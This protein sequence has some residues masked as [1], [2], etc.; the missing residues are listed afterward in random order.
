MQNSII[1]SASK[2]FLFEGL[3]ESKIDSLLKLCSP[4]IKTYQKNGVIYSPDKF[5]REV[6]IIIGGK[7]RVERLSDDGRAIPLN[8][9]SE[10]DAFGIVAAFSERK[11]F[12]THIVALCDSTVAFFTKNDV[13]RLIEENNK[14]ALNVIGF[15][16]NRIDFLNDKILTFSG[17]NVEQKLAKHIYDLYISSG[18]STFPFNKKKASEQ[19]NVG[20][21]SLYRAIDSMTSDGIISFD[22]RKIIIKDPQGLE[23]LL[24]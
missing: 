14:I 24:K 13:V 2:S 11:Y 8:D 5:Q 20:R 17:H 1:R 16:S 23:R 9:L 12:P 22:E 21:A 7:C 3:N 15:M 4:V 19:T 18:T 10:G 6:G